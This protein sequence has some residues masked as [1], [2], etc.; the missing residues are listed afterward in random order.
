MSEVKPFG[1]RV[2]VRLPP[3][4]DATPSG[5]VIPGGDE[6]MRRG[7]VA[8]TT[9]LPYPPG[10][11]LS[12]GDTVWWNAGC[13]SEIHQFDEHGQDTL[14]VVGLECIIAVERC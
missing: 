4:D 7:L 3:G 11:E 9:E 8:A 1:P 13:E 6:V 2:A 5:L 12:V 10:M 14:Y